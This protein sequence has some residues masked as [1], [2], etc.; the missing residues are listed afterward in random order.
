MAAVALEGAYTEA[1]AVGW[2][3]AHWRPRLTEVLAI[4]IWATNWATAV[5]PF[6]GSPT[7]SAFPLPRQG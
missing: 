6:P 1:A 2:A 7:P 4:D 3:H 5:S